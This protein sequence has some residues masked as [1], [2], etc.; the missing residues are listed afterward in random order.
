VACKEMRNWRQETA[1]S[2]P[3]NALLN[4]TGQFP[5]SWLS[6]SVLGLLCGM[7]SLAAGL[8]LCQGRVDARVDRQNGRKARDVEDLVN[9][10]LEGTESHLATAGVELFDGYQ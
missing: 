7:R 2:K 5:G 3:G 10:L 4:P 6:S 9:V 1:D 8:D